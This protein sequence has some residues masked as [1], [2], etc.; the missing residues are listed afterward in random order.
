M[1]AAVPPTGSSAFF[2]TY[3]QLRRSWYMFFFLSPLAEMALPLDDYAFIDRPVARLVVGLRRRP[4][5]WPGVKESIGD[6]EHLLAA[7]SYYR[8]L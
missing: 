5:T 6:P 1:T 4:G 2:L 8:A 3:A 7:I